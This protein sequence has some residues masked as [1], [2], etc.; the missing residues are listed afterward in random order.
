MRRADRLFRIVEYLKARKLVVTGESLANK[1]E[2][3]LRTIYRDIA[4]LGA[5]G[6][7]IIGE[8]GVGY[9]LDKDYVVRPLMFDI[10][11]LDALMLGAQMVE[12]WGDKEL[13]KAAHQAID[14]I[15]SVLPEN[16]RREIAETFLFSL[17]TQAKPV[18]TIDFSAVRRA[19]RSKNFVKFS[20][21]RGDGQASTRRVR[22]LCLAFF[23][24]VWLLL[25]WCEMRNDF[26]NFR[27]D[28]MKK[29]NI[30]KDYFQDEVGKRLQDYPELK[31]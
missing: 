7:P 9:M 26:R 24:P 10:E 4:V 6:V 22:P 27:L 20:Y 16:L 14:K 12:S 15:K 29:M 25:G 13:I 2:V 23:G 31:C 21:T 19:I 30:T 18:I 11:E 5:S 28:R 3:S 1:L 17:P 8:P